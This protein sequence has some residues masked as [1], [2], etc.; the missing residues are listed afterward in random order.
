MASKKRMDQIRNILRNYVSSGYNV[1][2][3]S[4]VLGISKNTVKEY[5]RR[6]QQSYSDIR[7]VLSLDDDLFHKLMYKEDVRKSDNR[8]KEFE[9]QCAGWLVELGKVGVT[10]SLLWAEYRQD[11]PDGYGYSQFCEYLRQYANRQNLT[12]TLEHRAGEVLMV[13]FA[14]KKMSWIDRS[15]GEKHDCEVLVTVLPFSQYSFCIAL[16]SQKIGD[17]IHGIN[18]ALRFIGA[19][20]QSILSDNLRSYV[21]K[22]ERYEPTF[23]QLCEQMGA[24]YQFDLQAARVRHPRDKASVENGVGQ[25]YRRIFAPLRNQE[26]YSIEQLNAAILEQLYQ[27]NEQAYQK[28]VGSRRSLFEQYEL[29]QMRPLPTDAFEVKKMT[30]AKIQRN[31]HIFLGE[32]KNFYSVPW[33]YAGKQSEVLYTHDTVEIYVAGK[34][35]ATHHRLVPNG[36][37]NRYQTR[38]EHMPQNHLE[39]RKS[40]GYDTAYFLSQ[41][42]LIGPHTHEAVR[43][44]LQGRIHEAQTYNSCKGV[45]HL[46]K[47]YSNERLENAAKRSL[48]AGKA[49]YTMLK[50]I[51]QLNLDQLER[52]EH[53]QLSFGFHENVRGPQNYQ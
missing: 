37:D 24:H 23:T 6:A 27:Q 12:L 52:E 16:P 51:L 28:K 34:R 40:Q 46:A 43:L 39:W 50:K 10:R 44:I 26:F 49:T 2:V 18:E 47:Q 11:K 42:A 38:E 1:K 14:G 31:Y 29:P 36:F 32:E 7:E 13:D 25:I 9:E 41:A 4:R 30:T 15:T 19:V 17:F 45:L 20:P 48:N 21:S 35:I 8:Q 22:S 5:V 3:T 53:N 33:Q